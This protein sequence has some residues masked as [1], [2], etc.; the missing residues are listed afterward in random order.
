MDTFSIIANLAAGIC[1]LLWGSFTVR[2]SVERVFS[3]SISSLLSA[4]SNSAARTVL[5]GTASAI[6]L[7]SATAT[8][9]LATGL[10][11]SGALTIYS[12]LGVVLG[13]DLGSAIAA[14]ILFLDLS[15]LPSIFI[16]L[17]M[18]VYLTAKL[19]RLKM[20]G[21][22]GMGIGLMLLSL[23]LIK[24]AVEPITTSSIS[25]TWIMILESVPWISILI[26]AVATWFSHSSVAMIL[27]IAVFAETGDLGPNVYIPMLVGANLGAGLI[28]IPLVFKT[29]LEARAVVVSNFVLRATLGIAILFSL[30]IWSGWLPLDTVGHGE[31]VIYLHVM[32]SVI[33][34][35][36]ASPFLSRIADFSVSRLSSTGNGTVE[37]L[38]LNAGFGLDERDIKKPKAAL[39]NAKREA[40]RLGDLTESYL[41]NSIEMF[42]AN[43]ESQIDDIVSFDDE[44]NVRN[45]V[46]HTYLS[47]VRNSISDSAQEATLDEILHFSSSMEDIGD[48][49][50]H[51]LSRL[52]KKRLYRGVQFSKEGQ[53]EITAAHEE[54]LKL[55]RLV[56]CQFAEGNKG[57][58]KQINKSAS[59]VKKV[60]TQSLTSHRRRLSNQKTLSIGTS[61]IHQDVLRDLLTIAFR[62]EFLTDNDYRTPSTQ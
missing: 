13:A 50:A 35:A 53:A 51:G 41:S 27:V 52:A 40:F 60:Y 16:V 22:I 47:R 6:C 10:L 56:L 8:I 17:G 11:N 55:L 14:R 37:Y 62:L 39:S 34:V 48:I 9:L 57:Y 49:I 33:L 42:R 20:F 5:I 58:E 31:M 26:V 2:S 61:S 24:A 7:Q 4:S 12:A 59:K 30:D 32:Y 19:T 25:S 23:Q 36:I 38:T 44:L 43:D 46:L 18:A 3:N 28:A 1:L 54:L 29:S 45:R 15:V 21:R